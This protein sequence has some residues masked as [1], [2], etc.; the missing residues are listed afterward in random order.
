MWAAIFVCCHWFS[1]LFFHSVK[2]ESNLRPSLTV[3]NCFLPSFRPHLFLISAHTVK[4]QHKTGSSSAP[5]I[6]C[7]CHMI[8]PPTQSITGSWHLAIAKLSW[9]SNGKKQSCITAAWHCRE[10]WMSSYFLYASLIHITPSGT[11]YVTLMLFT[12]E[13]NCD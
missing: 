13:I 12:F 9:L 8:N 11:D 2:M 7:F 10:E 6:L 3:N 1:V 4:T 5:R